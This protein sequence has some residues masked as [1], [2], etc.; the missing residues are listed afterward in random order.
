[1]ES[2]NWTLLGEHTYGPYYTSWLAYLHGISRISGTV[3]ITA[4]HPTGSWV[5]IYKQMYIMYNID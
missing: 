3:W 4:D 1:M 5:H 2:Q